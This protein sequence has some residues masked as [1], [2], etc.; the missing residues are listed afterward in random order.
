MPLNEQFLIRNQDEDG[1]D[2]YHV[3]PNGRT[4]PQAQPRSGPGLL[5]KAAMVVGAVAVG[6][7]AGHYLSRSN[8]DE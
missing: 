6:A 3:L 4:K 8:D 7:A 2:T 1:D 5:K